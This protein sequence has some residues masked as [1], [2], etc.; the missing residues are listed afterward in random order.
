MASVLTWPPSDG[1]LVPGEEQTISLLWAA[2]AERAAAKRASAREPGI[3]G[4]K[5]IHPLNGT[6]LVDNLQMLS[7]FVANLAPGFIRMDAPLYEFDGYSSFPVHYTVDEVLGGVDDPDAGGAGAHALGIL[8]T[9]E[10]YVRSPLADELVRQF[11]KDVV[12]W[13]RRFRYVLPPAY[14]AT[15]RTWSCSWSKQT[16]AGEEGEEPVTVT[17][18]EEFNFGEVFDKDPVSTQNFERTDRPDFS[19]VGYE[20]ANLVFSGTLDSQDDVS[21]DEY[22]ENVRETEERLAG[23]TVRDGIYVRNASG[24]DA[25]VLLMP[26][27]AT[28]PY[29]NESS[30]RLTAF[31]DMNFPVSAQSASFSEDL[32]GGKTYRTRE[33]EASYSFAADTA[34][35]TSTETQRTLK[36]RPDYSYSYETTKTS[37][38]SGVSAQRGN[39]ET[40]MLCPESLLG[41]VAGTPELKGTCNPHDWLLCLPK[42]GQ[43][44]VSAAEVPATD[45]LDNRTNTHP[46]RYN[47]FTCS[48]EYSIRLVPVLDFNQSYKFKAV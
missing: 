46:L 15:A 23:A 30:Y 7:A 11:F 20:Y 5:F 45:S 26:T 31:D 16:T 35:S 22:T 1:T 44:L 37:E 33:S 39:T 8:P 19:R 36:W 21:Y 10:A 29:R 6:L 2:A 13:L 41:L 25:D 47:R 14:Y 32:V 48:I 17:N 27:F 28:T 12:W 34:D 43:I 18:G 24:M 3:E 42:G 40:V 4:L 38:H 9:R